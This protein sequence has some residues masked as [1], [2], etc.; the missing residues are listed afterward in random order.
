[1]R[2]FDYGK[3]LESEAN[4]LM[5][6][7]EEVIELAFKAS[8]KGIMDVLD[9]DVQTGT[10]IGATMQ[11]YKH[12]KEFVMMQARAMDRM[13]ADLEELKEANENLRKQNEELQRLLQDLNR[14]VQKMNDKA[15]A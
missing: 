1:M 5:N 9:I 12:S 8:G 10:M 13:L 4:K 11:L 6:E 7:T 2:L 14:S 3:G 15:G